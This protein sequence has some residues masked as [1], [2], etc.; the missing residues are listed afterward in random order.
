MR[1]IRVATI[2]FLNVLPGCVGVKYGYRK[3]I[4]EGSKSMK[5]LLLVML[6]STAWS[7]MAQ[8]PQEHL[9]YRNDDPFVF[10][11]EGQKDP[12]KCWVPL[13]PYTTGAYMTMPYCQPINPYG[14]PW[15]PQ[16]YDSLGQYQRVCPLALKSGGWTGKK[17][18]NMSP[19]EH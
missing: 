9:R 15:T 7:A 14:K 5:K 6:C 1:L 18:A 3:E 8:S 2:Q 16:D 4:F 10:C 11:T 12:G 13:P 19:T 17:P